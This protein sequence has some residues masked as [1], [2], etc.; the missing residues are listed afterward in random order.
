M[1]RAKAIEKRREAALEEKKL[2][3]KNL[4]RREELKLVQLPFYTERLAELRNIRI[5]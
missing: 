2:L 4:E 5:A 1:A 3:L